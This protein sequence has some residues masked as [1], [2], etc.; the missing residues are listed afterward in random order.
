MVV[1]STLSTLIVGM[2]KMRYAPVQDMFKRWF[3]MSAVIL[4]MLMASGGCTSITPV[5]PQPPAPSTATYVPA[6]SL[7]PLSALTIRVDSLDAGSF[8]PDIYTCKG[9]GESPA[10]SWEGI[11]PGTK[12]LVLILDDPDAP[13]GRFT[14]W[15]VFNIPPES[16]ELAQAQPNAKVLV[17]GAQQGETSTG[18]RGYYPPCPPIGS[19]HRYIFRLYAVDMDI[20]QPTADRD[21]IDWALNGHTLEKTEFSTIFKR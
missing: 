10:V 6:Q 7:P 4:W 9:S 1:F 16:G 21:S 5:S 11:P 20:A 19:M 8:L 15:I 2:L 17:N 18:S 3:V 13:N 14:H 12:S